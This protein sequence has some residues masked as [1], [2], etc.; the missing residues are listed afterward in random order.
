MAV[1]MLPYTRAQRGVCVRG[2]RAQSGDDPIAFYAD[3][4]RARAI[5]DGYWAP[6]IWVK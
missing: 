5:D 1:L 2:G 6:R 4:V 3:V